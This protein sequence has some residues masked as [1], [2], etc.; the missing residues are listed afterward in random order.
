MVW[1]VLCDGL[2]EIAASVEEFHDSLMLVCLCPSSVRMSNCRRHRGQVV[3][4]LVQ[5][6]FFTAKIER[7]DSINGGTVNL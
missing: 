3:C 4:L 2:V 5:M 7:F 1:R 6:H